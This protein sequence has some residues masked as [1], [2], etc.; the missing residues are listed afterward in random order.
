MKHWPEFRDNGGLR[1]MHLRLD[2]Q[3][4]WYK[5]FEQ[6]TGA[7]PV[8]TWDFQWLFALWASGGCCVC[9]SQNLVNNVGYG[10]DATHT[11]SKSRNNDM[12]VFPMVFPMN[13]PSQIMMRKLA[14]NITCDN[15]FIGA[16]RYRY[17]IGYPW[18]RLGLIMD[19]FMH[20]VNNR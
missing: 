14:D 10:A 16:R 15:F 9:P 6:M 2:E 3:K 20:W 11:T 7:Q 19:E 8:D 4:F 18:M 5:I 17:W 12:D 1:K 13:H